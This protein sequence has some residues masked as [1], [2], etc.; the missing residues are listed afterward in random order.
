MS[1]TH[2]PVSA[3]YELSI[4]PAETHSL[5]CVREWERELGKPFSTIQLRSILRFTHESS[6]CM[7]IQETNF[8]IFTLWYRTPV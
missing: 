7:K 8:K 1:H 4:I 5:N 2:T 3:N 6:I